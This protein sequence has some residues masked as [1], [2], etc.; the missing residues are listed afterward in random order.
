EP[1]ALN[2]AGIHGMGESI[3]LLN[4][5]GM[6]E[7]WRRLFANRSAL[8]D[9][10]GE[11]GW[12]LVSPSEESHA[13]GIASFVH[14]ELDAAEVASKLRERGIFC[15]PRRGWLRLAPHFYQDEKH[16]RRVVEAIAGCR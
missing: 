11:L 13:A 3:G 9:G 16:M 1:G 14:S 12:R 6:N 15:H 8:A 4:E 5:V 7:V 2:H 10:L